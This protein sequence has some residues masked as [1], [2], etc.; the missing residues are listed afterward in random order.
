LNVSR[1]TSLEGM[2]KSLS[3]PQSLVICL[4][5]SNYGITTRI[6]IYRIVSHIHLQVNSIKSNANTIVNV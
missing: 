5:L 3:Q 6:L 1:T 2:D 4:G